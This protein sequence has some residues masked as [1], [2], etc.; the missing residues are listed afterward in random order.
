M[1]KG[2]YNVILT[3]AALV[4]RLGLPLFV[5]NTLKPFRCHTPMIR[6]LIIFLAHVIAMKHRQKSNIKCNYN[7]EK[8]VNPLRYGLVANTVL[9]KDKEWVAK[10]ADAQI[11]IIGA[12]RRR[13]AVVMLVFIKNK[14]MHTQEFILKG[15]ISYMIELYVK[16]KTI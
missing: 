11:R 10:F 2:N 12:G 6:P 3:F 13:V 1:C 16:L 5:T 4:N 9:T 15:K 8:N 7:K 14:I